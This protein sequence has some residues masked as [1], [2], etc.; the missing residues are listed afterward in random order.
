MTSTKQRKAARK[1]VNKAAIVSKKKA[2]RAHLPERVRIALGK[3]R[4]NRTRSKA[5][6][7]TA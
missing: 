7:L 5:K 3:E 6:T 4:A 2:H 1:N